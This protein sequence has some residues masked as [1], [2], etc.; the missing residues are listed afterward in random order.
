MRIGF[1]GL[2]IMGRPMSRNLLKAGYDLT[3]YDVVPA[4]VA[5]IATAGA[6]PA[7]SI[8]EISALPM[9]ILMLPD[10]PQVLQVTLGEGG[11]SESARPG[12]LVVDMSSIAP[13]AAKQAAA[14]L[15]A[16]GI[17]YLDA[18]VSGGEPKAI[19][20]TLYIM[21]GGSQEDFEEAYPVLM[22]MGASAVRIGEVGSGNIAKLANQVVVALNIAAISEAFLLAKL[23][24]TEPDAVYQAIR[25]GLAGSMVMEAKAPKIFD[26]N[27]KPGF[28][29][30]L[31][32]KD[33]SNAVSTSREIGAPLPL[34]SQV[35]EMFQAVKDSGDGQLDHSALVKYYENL[36][37]IE[38][39]KH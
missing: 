18:P 25:G 27:F 30:D 19:D 23:A 4:A 16:K 33:L 13:A 26:G 31:H 1:I 9:I 28:K 11:M 22:K 24:G 7:H 15:K 38:V 6:T 29:I 37:H 35:L 3:V 20:G 8:A 10:S 2:G 34:T 5:E 12:T 21:A 39:R 32:I 36:A 14:G 17:R